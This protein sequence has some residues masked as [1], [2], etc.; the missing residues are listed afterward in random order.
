MYMILE[1]I[2][3]FIQGCMSVTITTQYGRI[4]SGSSPLS[5]IIDN[6]REARI[7]LFESLNNFEGNKIEFESF[8]VRGPFESIKHVF[9]ALK[10]KD[11]F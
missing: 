6:G 10:C 9:I 11:K 8:K 7:S 2:K 1:T 3:S 4:H 5:T